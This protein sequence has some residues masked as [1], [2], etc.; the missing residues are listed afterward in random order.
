MN[1]Y[2][3]VPTILSQSVC[4]TTHSFILRQNFTIEWANDDK[5]RGSVVY[6]MNGMDVDMT[7]MLT[8]IKQFILKTFQR[9]FREEE[10]ECLSLSYLRP[11]FSPQ[12]S[13]PTKYIR[14]VIHSSIIFCVFFFLFVPQDSWKRIKKQTTERNETKRASLMK[15]CFK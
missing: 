2:Y 1:K 9:H 10:E 6:R 4:Q 13:A 3:C 15:K 7:E 12:H 11:Y 8:E 5:F 14:R